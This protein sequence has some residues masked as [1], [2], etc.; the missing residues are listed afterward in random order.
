MRSDQIKC[1]CI[2]KDWGYINNKIT[3]VEKQCDKDFGNHDDDVNYGLNEWNQNE[4][5][6]YVPIE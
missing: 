3:K 6:E 4:K 1:V 5:W 2:I